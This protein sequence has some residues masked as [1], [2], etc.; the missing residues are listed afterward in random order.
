MINIGFLFVILYISVQTDI[1]LSG[2][3]LNED[4]FK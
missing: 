3:E 1:L 2:V 4:N